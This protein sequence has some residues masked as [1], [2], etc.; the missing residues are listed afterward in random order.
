MGDGLKSGGMV[1]V[2]WSCGAGKRGEGGVLGISTTLYYF[3]SFFLSPFLLSFFLSSS[4]LLSL[5]LFFAL[6]SS[7]QQHL[8]LIIPKA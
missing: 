2:G 8:Q 3:M 7:V 1:L 4:L 6:L 5:S